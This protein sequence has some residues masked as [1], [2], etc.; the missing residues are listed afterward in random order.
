[1]SKYS[2]Y[3]E[4]HISF[5]INF[6]NICEL[7]LMVLLVFKVRLIGLGNLPAPTCLNRILL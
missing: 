3:I 7:L 1:M 6:E 5:K 4:R 2:V